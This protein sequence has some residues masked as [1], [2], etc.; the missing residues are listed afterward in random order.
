MSFQGQVSPTSTKLAKTP[1]K[2]EH[3]KVQ[4]VGVFLSV[5]EVASKLGKTPIT[6]ARWCESGKLPA[7][8]KPYGKKVTWLISPQALELIA[9]VEALKEEASREE[10]NKQALSKPHREYK[11][12]WV[13][14]MA[15]GT[16]NGKVYSKRTID[17]YTHY[18]DLYLSK[19]PNLNIEN[20]KKELMAIP[21]KMFAKREKLYK[22]LLCFARFLTQEQ[23]LEPSFIE[24][25]KPL[26]PRRHLPPK[27]FTVDE[28][29][30]NKLLLV[31]ETVQERL[32]VL[33]LA[34]TGLRAS[35]A[36]N[37]TWGDVDL[38]EGRL[39]VRLGKGN[40]NRKVGLTARL[41]DALKE[42]KANIIGSLNSSVLLSR[43]GEPIERTGLF[44]RVQRLGQLAGVKVSP[45]ALR[46]AFVTIN[47]NKGRPLVIL[48]RSCGH[49]DIKTTMSYCL[50]SEQEVIEAMREW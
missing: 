6:I 5:Q 19:Y 21:A 34:H 7:T 40:K 33:L 4:H 1:T 43:H 38:I 26:F 44:R 29:G 17:D 12:A 13:N 10:Q 48:Q 2:V 28:G 15:K 3:S 49:S 14:A 11:K 45:H 8:S 47:A 36:C 27:R 16:L 50:T 35:E 20:L 18:I 46:R 42:Q 30:V 9:R 37:L 31:C 25:I 41:K 32:I 23:A 39:T 24:D 22:A